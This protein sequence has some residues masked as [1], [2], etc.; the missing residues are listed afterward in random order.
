MSKKS[1]EFSELPPKREKRTRE[2][3]LQEDYGDLQDM[4]SLNEY[5]KDG[6]EKR[7]FNEQYDRQYKENDNHLVRQLKAVQIPIKPEDWKAINHPTGPKMP[8]SHP[9]ELQEGPE[10]EANLNA[11]SNK[12]LSVGNSKTPKTQGIWGGKRKTSKKK[13]KKSKTLK[14]KTK[15]RKFRKSKHKKSI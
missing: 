11:L 13:M 2:Q 6:S 5:L 7:Q 1:V 3:M 15:K 12:G 10:L 8:Y 14:I 9:L 4:G